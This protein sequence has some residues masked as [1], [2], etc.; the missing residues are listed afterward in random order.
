MNEKQRTKTSNLLSLVLRHEPEHLGIQLDTSGWVE[1]ETLLSALERHGRPLSR[2]ELQEIV[3]TNEK[4]RFAF[5]EDGSRIRASQGHSVEVSLGYLPQTPPERL[6]HGT[7]TRFLPSIRAQ[8]LRKGGRHHVHLSADAAAAHKVGQ[9]H[10]KPAIL[11][12]QAGAMQAAGHAF[13]LSEN[14][15]WLTEH[16]PVE[17][18]EFPPEDSTAQTSSSVKRSSRS[19]FAKDTVAICEAGYYSTPGGRVVQIA[20]ALH[21]AVSHTVLHS[22]EAP[23]D[24]SDSAPSVATKFSATGETTVEAL[25]RMAKNPQG[26]LACLNFASAKNPGGGFLGG[27]EAQEE[28][29]ARSSGLYPCLLAAPG[30]Y[31]RNRACRTTLYLD[32]AIWSPAVPFF[33]DDSGALLED[34]VLASV[35]TA[36]APNAGAV[37]RNEPHR[38]PEI[39]PTLRRR[40]AF[41]L[42]IAAARGVRRLVLGAWGCGVF[43]NDP[44][45]V[46][47]MFGDLLLGSGKF[48]GVF[49]EVA[50][51]IYDRSPDQ[52]VLKP[53]EEVFRCGPASR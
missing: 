1:V 46:A 28:S 22:L 39:E 24:H 44:T 50:F 31:E 41:V 49:D 13:F 20:D 10:G 33:R 3:E 27:A 43:R 17:F 5:N 35:I 51:A 2:P 19:Q 15:V 52:S 47:R 23:L 42:A 32:L 11:M 34:P 53:F 30:Y 9:R 37:D 40:G 36:P 14:G 4:K 25:R 48:A 6:F 26:H 45:M 18:I 29:L 8:G 38:I 21:H 12:V 16:V 7:A